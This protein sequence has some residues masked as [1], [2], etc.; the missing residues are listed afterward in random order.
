VSYPSDSKTVKNEDF[1]MYFNIG[2]KLSPGEDVLV[3]CLLLASRPKE[4][5]NHSLDCPQEIT[6]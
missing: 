3:I 2:I 1:S 6:S 4:E 5:K